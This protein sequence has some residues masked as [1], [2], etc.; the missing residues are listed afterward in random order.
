M[1]GGQYSRG[2][3]FTQTTCLYYPIVVLSKQYVIYH[4]SIYIHMYIYTYDFCVHYACVQPVS[5]LNNYSYLNLIGR[6]KFLR[7]T[8]S[9]PYIEHQ[10]D[11]TDMPVDLAYSY[12]TLDSVYPSLPLRFRELQCSV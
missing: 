4:R 3:V 1:S 10:R 8:S 9:R 11:E 6:L 12:L 2:T 7:M 5:C